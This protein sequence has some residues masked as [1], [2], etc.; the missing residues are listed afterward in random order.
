MVSAASDGTIA[1][2]DFRHLSD[3]ESGS[4]KLCKVVRS[5]A[6]KLYLHD[7]TSRRKVCGPVLLSR[8]PTSVEKRSI[9]CV[10]RDAVIREWDIR[11]GDVMSEHATGHCDTISTFSSFQ[12]ES[13]L[14]TQ[15]ETSG[16]DGVAG[17]IT[18]S[19]DGTVRMRSLLGR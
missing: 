5:A 17:T 8:G 1:A 13:L 12:G 3:A 19:W 9:L 4:S 14:D 2:W 18:T 11:T 10:G 16:S 6:A 7:F 15:L